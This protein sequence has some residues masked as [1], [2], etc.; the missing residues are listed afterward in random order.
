MLGQ[1]LQFLLET[2]FGLFVLALLLRFFLQWLRAPV[3]FLNA[4]LVRQFDWSD[5]RV[6]LP[7][8]WQE[9]RATLV[10]ARL[11][12]MY[13]YRLE[14]LTWWTGRPPPYLCAPRAGPAPAKRRPPDDP[15]AGTRRWRSR[16][17]DYQAS[18]RAEATLARLL[19]RC[20]EA[21]I[22]C[23]LIVPPASSIQRAVYGAA[24]DEAFRAALARAMDGHD[25]PLVDDRARLP[26]EEFRD[27]SHTNRAGR[28]RYGRIVA[29]EVLAPRYSGTNTN[30]PP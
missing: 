26:D 1:A 30:A 12:P 25:V 20:R 18:D 23:V 24:L 10:R 28:E 22:A 15:A 21:D 11:F 19:A 17:A 4:Q 9:N 27:G 7:E 2:F 3:P 16:L 8:L 5:V 6:W 14:L 13:H 29:E